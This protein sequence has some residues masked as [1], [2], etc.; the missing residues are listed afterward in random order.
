MIPGGVGSIKQR[1]RETDEVSPEQNRSAG[2][3]GYSSLDISRSNSVG[4]PYL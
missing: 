2:F 1:N 4:V 3:A